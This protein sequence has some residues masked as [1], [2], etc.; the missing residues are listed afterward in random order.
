MN[1]TGRYACSV[2]LSHCQCLGLDARCRHRHGGTP[3]REIHLVVKRLIEQ[4]IS[5]SKE[6][7]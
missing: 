1:V 4:G 2:E 3:S 7:Q 6:A 5:V